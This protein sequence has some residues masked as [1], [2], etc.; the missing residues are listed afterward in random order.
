[1]D[2]LLSTKHPARTAIVTNA[3]RAHSRLGQP[4][5]ARGARV[6]AVYDARDCAIPRYINPIRSI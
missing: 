6:R 5:C 3:A 1:M 4:A 2:F